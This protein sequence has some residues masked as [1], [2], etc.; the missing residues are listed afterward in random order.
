LTGINTYSGDTIIST[1]TLA[2]AGSGSIANS[3]TILVAASSTLSVATRTD[4]TL[5]L[6]ASQ[7]LKG[8]GAVRGVVTNEGTVAPGDLIGFLTITGSYYQAG[9]LE[10]E[11]G[12]V[13]P[14]AGHDV[15]A[16]SS[17]A[18]LGGTLTVKLTNSFTP[19]AGNAFTVLTASAVSGTFATT[20][21]PVLSG[22]AWTV[23]Y[24]GAAVVLTVVEGGPVPT[25]YED[26]AAGFGLTGTNVYD[27][28]DPDNDGYAN[29]LE[30]SQGSNPTSDTS[31]V[32][33]QMVMTNGA[34]RLFIQRANSATDIVYHVEAA[35]EAINGATW[36]A[37]ASNV[38]GVWEGTA[39]VDDNNTG[40]VHEVRIVDPILAATNRFLRLRVSR[41]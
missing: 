31:A 17:S 8:N 3:A 11:L 1:G 41:P 38:L 27:Q 28:A 26:W 21:L 14:G 30:Y 6:G 35:Y 18:T 36:S 9:T 33:L 16:V 15:L 24:P 20:N 25:P 37:L 5:N 32:K 40:A 19:V 29:L 39:T 23:D 10:V 2:L 7:L 13:L 12:G 34:A 4:G 22:L